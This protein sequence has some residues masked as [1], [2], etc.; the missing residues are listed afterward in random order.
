MKRLT[1]LLFVLTAV[2]SCVQA[3]AADPHQG[4]WISWRGPLQTG[5]SLE[6]YSDYQFEE[7]PVWTDDIAGRGTPV[8]YDDRLYTWGYRG[9]G[10]NLEEVLQAR[11]EKTGEI[12]W[13]QGTHDFISDTIYNRYT[14]GA[15]AI[16]PETENVYVAS[17]YGL[18]TCYDKE[19]EQLW[20]HSMMERFGRLSFPNGRAG[21]PVIDGDIVIFRGVNSYWGAQGPARDRFFG[22]DKN[23]G[24]LLWSSTPGVGP[25]FLRDSSFSQPWVETRDGKR[26]FYAGTGCGNIVCVNLMDG[27]PLWRFQVS[28]GGVNSA[29]V[30]HGDTLIGIHGKENLDST[31]MGRLF[32]IELPEDYDNPGGEVDPDQGGAPRLPA[33]AEIWRAPLEMFTSSPLLHDGKVYQVVKTGELYCVDAETG[34]TLWKEKLANSQ[35]HASPALADGRLYAP[36]YPGKF[37]V[38]D[39]TGEEPEIEHELQL[40]G[41]CIGSPAICNGRVY[42][43]TT[44]KFYAFEIGHG[45]IEWTDTPADPMPEAGEPAKLMPVPAD[46]LLRAGQSKEVTIRKADANG[47][48]VG[49]VEGDAAWETYVPPTA[50]VEARMEAGFEGNTISAPGDAELSAGAWKVEADGLTGFLRGRVIADLPYHEDFEEGFEIGESGFAHPPLPWIGARFKWEVQEKDGNKV[51][52]KTLDRVLFQRALSFIGDPDLS[53]YTMTADVMTDGN[54]R[55]KSVVGLINQ[56]YLIYLDGNK[57]LLEVSSN[58]ERIKQSAPFTVSANQWYTL[59]TRVDV[60]EDGSGVVRAKAWEKG[61][62]EPDEWTLEVEHADAHDR[63]A[64]GLFGFAPQSMETVFIDDIVVESNE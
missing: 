20:Q 10:P 64:P 62:P 57:R 17:T 18:I 14:I 15:P 42:V 26:V 40:D 25:P 13:E 6:H 46:V 51:L 2:G 9:A 52:Q 34:E 53:N 21:A 39:V 61:E 59:K 29:P 36:T 50:K 19:G 4:S 54:R 30:I 23:T 48:P 47:F 22:F 60:A 32:A 3:R 55:M 7:E 1:R 43:H 49:E 35:L 27:T 28:K 33:E 37:Y 56:H 44:E 31:E 58:H 63:G 45:E 24:E 11:D 38:I 12:L 16:D 41:N 8:I 5:V